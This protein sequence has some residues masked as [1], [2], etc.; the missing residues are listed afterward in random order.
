MKL[1][2]L[3]AEVKLREP[4]S[5]IGLVVLMQNQYALRV[6]AA[7]DLMPAPDFFIPDGS[8]LAQAI[9]RDLI[10]GLDAVTILEIAWECARV[11]IK[12]L[13]RRSGIHMTETA[14]QVLYELRT[15]FMVY[16][17]GTLHSKAREYLAALTN[18]TKEAKA[19]ASG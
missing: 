3:L 13:A 1:Q 2:E 5:S 16:P 8:R 14:A 17:D 11:D 6:A 18:P 4:D 19:E 7:F 10:G 9:E 15:N 12:D